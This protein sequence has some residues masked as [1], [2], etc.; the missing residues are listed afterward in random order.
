MKTRK[1]LRS[2]FTDRVSNT[3]PPTATFS[4]RFLYTD[5]TISNLREIGL[6]HDRIR[7]T[8]RKFVVL[9][10]QGVE[11]DLVMRASSFRRKCIQH[12]DQTTVCRKLTSTLT[13]SINCPDIG[14]TVVQPEQRAVNRLSKLQIFHM[15][16]T[17]EF[18]TAVSFSGFS[19]RGHHAPRTCNKM[20]DLYEA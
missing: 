6:L 20:A 18:T 3:Q 19:R 16:G 8:H 14:P 9:L 13:A 1:K 2:R 5:D 10:T 7:S 15:P 17:K 11:S 4:N 12:W